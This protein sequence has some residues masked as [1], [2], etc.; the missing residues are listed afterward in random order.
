MHNR[1]TNFKEES[2]IKNELVI[3]TNKTAI[4]TSLSQLASVVI[5]LGTILWFAYDIRSTVRGN[6][7]QNVKLLTKIACLQK[8]QLYK[9]DNLRGRYT[10]E[11]ERD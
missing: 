10:D 2:V 1:K 7:E 6:I 3:D 8:W 11:C 4:R 9:M 5:F